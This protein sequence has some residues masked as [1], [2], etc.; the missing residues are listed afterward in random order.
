[1]AETNAD[2]SMGVVVEVSIPGAYDNDI[3]DIDNDADF[4][5]A[6][7]IN[8]AQ[9]AGTPRPS[10]A[11]VAQLAGTPRSAATIAFDAL[12]PV[13]AASIN[14][15]PSLRRPSANTYAGE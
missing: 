6:A 4:L 12:A 9:L 5:F 7:E 11:Y 2:D 1:M 13:F 8:A 3:S 10:E 14:E 15:A